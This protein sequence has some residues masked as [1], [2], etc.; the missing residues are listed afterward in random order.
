MTVVKSVLEI[1]N[2]PMKQ[3]NAYVLEVKDRYTLNE[4]MTA[5]G[6]TQHELYRF[7]KKH[8]YVGKAR[9][10]SHPKYTAKKDN[11]VVG[12]SIN[13]DNVA[14]AELVDK[15]TAIGLMTIAGK[16]YNVSV[17]VKEV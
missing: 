15:L 1:N 12:F 16:K 8:G 11:P 5:W 2:M 9:G 10:K 13:L 6:M 4:L 14:G 7:L 3:A 17:V